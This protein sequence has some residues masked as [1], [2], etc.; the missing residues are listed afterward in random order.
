MS[1]MLTAAASPDVPVPSDTLTALVRRVE[2]RGL[3]VRF[4]N[5]YLNRHPEP[6]PAT[7]SVPWADFVA[8]LR[9]EKV[10][11]TDTELAAE[12]AA[13]ERA[14]RREMARRA[15]GNAAAARI[16]VEGDP[17]VQRARAILARTRTARDVFTAARVPSPA[18]G[19]AAH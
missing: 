16:A 12:R 10:A 14:V 15:G 13:L 19:R 18:K 11:M 2:S 6:S 17:S 3:A 1:Q 4:A 7:A 9:A 5:Q 8:F